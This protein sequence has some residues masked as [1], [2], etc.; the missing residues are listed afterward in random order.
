MTMDIV[1]DIKEGRHPLYETIA[2]TFVPNGIYLN[3]STSNDEKW[4]ENGFERILLLTGANFSG[5][6]VYLSQCALITFLA[7]IGS[8]V[9][10]SK[11]TIGLTDKILT[12]IMSKESISKMQSTFLIDSQQMS[13]CLKLM[14]EKSLLI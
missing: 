2:A 4:F 6:S 14:T 5:K 8:Y 1:L 7:H 3:G 11:A 13:K 10:A 12:R 9:P